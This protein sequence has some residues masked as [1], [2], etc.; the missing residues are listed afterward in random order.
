MKGPVFALTRPL[1]LAS[2][3][4]RRA[5][6]LRMLGFD[7]TVSP[8]GCDETMPPG[9]QPAQVPE[10]L[11]RIKAI[12]VSRTNTG[13]LALGADT[14]V[15]VDD[16]ILNKPADAAEALEMLRLLRGRTHVV[17]TGVALAADGAVLDAG[18][19]RS[20]VTFSAAPGDEDL[21]AYVNGG[22]PMDKAGAYA[23]QGRGAFLVEGIRGCFFNVM[24]LPIQRTLR[25]LGPYRIAGSAGTSSTF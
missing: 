9:L 1:L 4:P 20:E 13:A 24:G 8:S 3:S 16:R 11:A 23:V 21:R 22:E 14:I 18:V 10:A 5:E 7:F 25:L 12:E 15:V 17:Y 19:E 2:Q 6:I